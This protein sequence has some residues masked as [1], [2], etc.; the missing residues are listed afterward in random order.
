MSLLAMVVVSFSID[1][2]DAICTSSRKQHKTR[3]D[4][5][6]DGIAP[7]H[8]L[9]IF[10]AMPNQ[11]R[12]GLLCKDWM[13]ERVRPSK[14]QLRPCCCCCGGCSPAYLSR[15]CHILF[16]TCVVLPPLLPRA[17]DVF[18][19]RGHV[20]FLEVTLMVF[21]K[22]L[23]SSHSLPPSR[24]SGLKKQAHVMCFCVRFGVSA[25]AKLFC[26]AAVEAATRSACT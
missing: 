15:L 2:D 21:R 18:G 10:F 1:D 20:A 17:S 16:C 6:D 13:D 7:P 3:S 14:L 24:R 25:A 23:F 9:D 4:D 11:Q 22:G 19:R 5:D 8:R 26:A 12:C